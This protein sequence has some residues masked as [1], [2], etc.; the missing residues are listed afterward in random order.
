MKTQK[1]GNEPLLYNDRPIGLTIGDFWRWNASDLLNNTLRGQ[2]CE[3]V[4]SSALGI[5]LSGTND[6]WRPYDILF[7]NPE[8]DKPDIRIEVKSSAFL[9]SWNGKALSSPRFTIRPTRAWNPETG[10]EETVKRQSD[11]YVFCLYSVTDPQTADPL[12]LNGW[13]FMVLPTHILDELCG[14]QKTISLLSLLGL[15]PLS[16]SYAGIR[17]AVLT[18]AED[19]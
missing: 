10:Y 2:F 15:N 19:N 8:P 17:E 3:F 5:D 4:V 12:N 14:N 7:P 16:T 9:Q 13:K 18:C 1:T 11:V 6:D